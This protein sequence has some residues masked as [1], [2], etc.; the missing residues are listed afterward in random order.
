MFD[1]T[2]AC[3]APMMPMSEAIDHPHL[4]ARETYVERE[5]ITQPAPAPRFSRRPP[6]LTMPPQR[7]PAPTPA[8]R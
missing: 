7:R 1:A 4:E 8:R 2:D 5:G 3:V 6:S